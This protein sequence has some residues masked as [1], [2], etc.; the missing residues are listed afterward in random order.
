M[1]QKQAEDLNDFNKLLNHITKLA[2]FYYTTHGIQKTHLIEGV[3][4][5]FGDAYSK[6]IFG[7]Q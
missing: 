3:R 6:I 2:V 4:L 5:T 1:V 7:E